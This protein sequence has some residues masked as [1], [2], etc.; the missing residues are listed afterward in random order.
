M[1]NNLFS[2]HLLSFEGRINRETFWIRGIVICVLIIVLQI[3]ATLMNPFPS[4]FGVVV[5]TLLLA[6]AAGVGIF[7]YLVVAWAGMAACIRRCH[8]LDMEGW[9]TFVWGW[10]II[11]LPF[12]R[13]TPKKNSFGE[14][15]QPR[16]KRSHTK[17]GAGSPFAPFDDE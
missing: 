11:A 15:P 3:T 5:D 8:D 4:K 9:Y 17:G 13:G 12:F 14:L 6:L 16:P 2:H 7:A 1:S 10:N